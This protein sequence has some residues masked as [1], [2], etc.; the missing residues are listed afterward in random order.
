MKMTYGD[1]PM[2]YLHRSL[3][4][5]QRPCDP[6]LRRVVSRGGRMATII[7]LATVAMAQTPRPQPSFEFSSA[8]SSL[9]IPAEVVAD[10]LVLMQAAVNGHTGW[11]ILDNAS[12][13]FTVD[14]EYAKRTSLDV[15][16]RASARGG[17]ASAIDAGVVHDVRISLKGLD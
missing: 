2:S 7:V 6:M 16:D 12:Q 10:G 13:G 14:T 15:T 9:C 17:G 8:G 5:R 3:R 1:A 4:G 11:F